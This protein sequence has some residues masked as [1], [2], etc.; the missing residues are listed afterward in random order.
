MR[1]RTGTMRLDWKDTDR[2]RRAGSALL[3]A[4][5]AD[6][7]RIVDHACAVV[8]PATCGRGRRKC[9]S[10]IA[11]PDRKIH[12]HAA[13]RNSRHSDWRAS[14][15]CVHVVS[16]NRKRASAPVSRLMRDGSPTRIR[17]SATPSL[18]ALPAT[19]VA[20]IMDTGAMSTVTPRMLDWTLPL[21]RWFTLSGSFYRGQ[22]IGGIG[23]GI[24]RSV[25]SSGP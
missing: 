21:N 11:S 7:I 16:H 8:L 19:T 6:L 4:Q 14:L 13:G 12:R 2:R 3:R 18:S 23:G 22:A 17:C 1:L 20:K 9:T 25:L 15:L 5:L 24:G 10:I